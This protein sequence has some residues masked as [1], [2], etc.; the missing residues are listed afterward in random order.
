METKAVAVVTGASRGIGKACKRLLEDRGY[1]V[2]GTSRNPSGD[3]RKLDI[4]DPESIRDFCST[5]SRVDVLISNAGISQIGAVEDL[6]ASSLRTVLDTNLTGAIE[7]DS[8]ISSIMRDQGYGRIIH[9]SSLAARFPVPYSSVYAASKAG[10]DAYTMAFSQEMRPFGI[11]VGNVFFDFV[12]T[13]LAQH[14]SMPEESA[15]SQAVVRAKAKRD[16]SLSAGR[17]PEAVARA[18]VRTACSK[19]LHV[20]TAIGMRTRIL[21]VIAHI[22]PSDIK[23]AL[24]RRIFVSR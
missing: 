22:L 18:I 4:T 16:A 12:N 9:V 1:Q 15:Y 14:P 21:S 6:E 11:K 2:V 10:L 24:L 8:V 23:A 13:E 5:L 17:D 20:Y 7:L 19:R 3:L